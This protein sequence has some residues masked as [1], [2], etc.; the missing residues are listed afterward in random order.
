M[1]TLYST[2]CAQGATAGSV[3][4]QR[5]AAHHLSAPRRRTSCSKSCPAAEPQHEPHGNVHALTIKLLLIFPPAGSPGNTFCQQCMLYSADQRCGHMVHK[6]YYCYIIGNFYS[7]ACSC[8]SAVITPACA[9]AAPDCCSSAV[10]QLL[11]HAN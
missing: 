8:Y 3:K 4:P 5:A 1:T 11:L 6:A 9:C 2:C 10:W 7:L